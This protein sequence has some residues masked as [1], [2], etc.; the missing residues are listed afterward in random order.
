MCRRALGAIVWK[1][2]SF[3]VG[4]FTP[5]LG[6]SDR[7]VTTGTLVAVIILVIVGWGWSSIDA[8]KASSNSSNSMSVRHRE[9]THTHQ[10]ISVDEFVWQK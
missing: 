1:P 8:R 5:I 9:L 4:H 3:V 10:K 6:F 7:D 2:F